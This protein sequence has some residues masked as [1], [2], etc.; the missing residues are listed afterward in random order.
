MGRNH[1]QVREAPLAA[2]D[3]VLLRRVQLEQVAD[4]RRQ[5]VLVVFEMIGFAVEAAQRACDIGGH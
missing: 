3:L 2:L 5:Y 4:R 1:R